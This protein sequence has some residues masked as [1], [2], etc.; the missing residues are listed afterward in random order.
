MRRCLL[1]TALA[2][3]ALACADEQRQTW[4]ESRCTAVADDE[5]L[6]QSCLADAAIDWK[7]G[8]R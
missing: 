1:L 3:L 5:A 7:N 4:M 6:H 2:A 8:V